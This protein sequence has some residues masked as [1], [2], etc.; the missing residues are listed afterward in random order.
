MSRKKK[1][2]K[3][4][5]QFSRYCDMHDYSC[6]VYD[7]EC[8]GQ[9]SKGH[10]KKVLFTNW[11]EDAL[12]V[13]EKLTEGPVVLVGSSIGGWLSIITGLKLKER[14]HGLGEF[15]FHKFF[16]FMFI[17]IILSLV[18]SGSELRL[19]TLPQTQ[20]STSSR[21]KYFSFSRNNSFHYDQYNFMRISLIFQKDL[22]FSQD[23]FSFMVQFHH[24]QFSFMRIS[25]VS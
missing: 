10:L 13:T 18:F 14:L 7:H 15:E 4:I 3:S 21:C 2:I 5:N 9:S 25:L 20:S 6:V 24:D 22:K 23:Y 12:A 17:F 11:V 8:S 16:V 1:T 19:A